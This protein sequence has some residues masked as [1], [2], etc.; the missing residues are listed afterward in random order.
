MT[1]EEKLK[2]LLDDNAEDYQVKQYGLD[3]EK[4]L[5]AWIYWHRL[6]AFMESAKEYFGNSLFYDGGFEIYVLDGSVCIEIDEV[7]SSY[8]IDF[9]EFMKEI[10][11]TT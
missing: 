5:L 9:D 10:E 1:D 7:F 11:V 3:N 2:R 6:D 4:H 8:D